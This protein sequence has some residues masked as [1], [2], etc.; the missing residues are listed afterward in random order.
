MRKA[1]ELEVTHAL[2]GEAPIIV[3]TYNEAENM[4][5]LTK[6]I[7]ER[8]PDIHLLFVDDNTQDR[9]RESIQACRARF[10]EKAH[11]IPR[12]KKPGLG[13]AYITGFWAGDRDYL[14]ADRPD[15]G[16]TRGLAGNS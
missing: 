16:S 13:T 3:P 12:P 1:S 9:T 2:K 11:L 5:K 8:V 14:C 10:P 7:W 6:G 15:I 4:E